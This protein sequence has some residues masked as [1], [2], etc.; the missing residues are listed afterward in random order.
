[1]VFS[2]TSTNTGI[3]QQARKMMRVDATQWP[4]ANIVNSA[5]NYLDYVAGFFIGGDKRFQWDDTN[6]SA[7]PEGTEDMTINQTDYSF[8][9]DEQNNRILTLIGISRIDSS[10]K[11]YA[12]TQV[13]RNDPDYDITTFGVSSGIPTQYD[14]IADNVIRLNFKPSA[15]V[16]NGLKFYF[17]RTP[18]YFTASDTTKA[19]GVA[20]LLHRG[21][22]IACAYDGAITLGLQ[23]AQALGIER[24]IEEKKM[25]QYFAGRNRDDR[26]R[27]VPAREN[28]K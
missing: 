17:Q 6:H 8:L 13:D 22:V 18:S 24:G 16:T 25:E 5:N 3:V 14:K 27:M 15:T 26:G 19:P 23:N 10:G 1:M 4:T 12:L 9:T 28:N 7:L 21:F 20:P 11:E 2:D